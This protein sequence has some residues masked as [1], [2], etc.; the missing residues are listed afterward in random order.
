MIENRQY[1]SID[2]AI[3]DIK[4]GAFV[5]VVDDEDRENEGDLVMAAE[6]VTAEAI[7]FCATHARGLICVALTRER[8]DKLGLD[9]MVDVNTARLGTRFTVSVDAVQGTS[10]GISANDRAQTVKVL[11]SSSTIPEDLARP[12]HVFPIEAVEGGVLE[13]PGHTEASVDLARLACFLSYCPT[14]FPKTEPWRAN[15]ICVNLHGCTI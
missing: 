12:G 5:I 8:L 7:N 11:A 2:E 14:A 1:N 13:R 3:E 15:L 4:R 10:T 6:H 9:Q